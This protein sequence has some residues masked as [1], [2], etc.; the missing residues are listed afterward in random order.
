MPA[1]SKN[2]VA[3]QAHVFY[4]A[5]GYW[6]FYCW[7]LH[8][9][10]FTDGIGSSKLIKQHNFGIREIIFNYFNRLNVENGQLN[11]DDIEFFSLILFVFEGFDICPPGVN[12][13]E[14]I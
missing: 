5:P 6:P 11:N 14:H 9:L 7:Y 3:I 2:L 13:E 8:L 10:N 4:F 12:L 1:T